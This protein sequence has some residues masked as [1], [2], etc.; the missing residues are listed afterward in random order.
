MKVT[1]KARR[2]ARQLFRLCMVDGHLDPAR[3]RAVA[4]GVASSKGRGSLAVLTDFQRMVRLSRDRHHA[5]VE[6]AAALPDDLRAEV[7]ASITKLYGAG[8]ET[9][10]NENPALIA[11]M[12]IRVGSDVYDGS[13]R[14]KL[15]AIDA[16]LS[17]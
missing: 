5:T 7:L 9:S 8:I 3:V 13:V 16:G 17:E 12:R 1:R 2:T 11:G 14:G 15:A 10:F 4:A 6:T